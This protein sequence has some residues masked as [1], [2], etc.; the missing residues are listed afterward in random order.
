MKAI[1]QS[2]YGSPAVVLSLRE[3]PTPA[4]AADE[5]LVRMHAAGVH[6]DVWHL[7][8]GWPYVLR[9]MGAGL[10]RP[11]NPVPGIDVA[12]VVEAVGAAVTRFKPGDA[13]FGATVFM[14]WANG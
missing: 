10:R 4:P 13:V 11:K 12:G 1:V 6:P 14:R 9:V 3:V 7:V 5:V 2:A 8:A